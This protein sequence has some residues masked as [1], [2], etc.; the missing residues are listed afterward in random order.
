MEG[1]K[2]AFA[3]SHLPSL[4]EKHMSFLAERPSPIFAERHL[5]IFDE[6]QQPSPIFAERHL[7]FLPTWKS[8]HLSAVAMSIVQG[9]VSNLL[10]RSSGGL[11]T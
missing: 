1:V 2:E 3:E 4:A 10:G 11:R 5:P 6:R 7:P 9:V 8:D